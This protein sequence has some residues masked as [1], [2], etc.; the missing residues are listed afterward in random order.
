MDKLNKQEIN[1]VANRVMSMLQ[2]RQD[3]ARKKALSAYEPDANYLQAKEVL[4]KIMSLNIQK[5]GIIN[6]IRELT[7]EWKRLYENSG[8]TAYYT[9]VNYIDGIVNYKRVDDYLEVLKSNSIPFKALP[10]LDE[11]K[12]DI[13]LANIDGE[14]KVDQ[15]IKDL[16]YKYNV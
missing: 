4:E 13:I 6:Q 5:E 14:F 3:K 7:S 15:Y 1:A 10:S 16:V 8:G 11:I 2:D 9:F 12:E